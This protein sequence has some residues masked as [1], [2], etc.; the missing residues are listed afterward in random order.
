M[1]KHK[2]LHPPASALAIAQNRLL[3]KGLF[4][5]LAIPVAPYQAVNSLE[6]LQAAVAQ[7]W[8]AGLYSKLATGGYDGKGQFVL[9][10]A[11]SD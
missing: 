3:E 10:T 6:S 7:A 8:S 4:D 11:R 1:T 9:R 5:E 2:D